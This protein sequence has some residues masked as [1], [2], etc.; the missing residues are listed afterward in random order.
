MSPRLPVAS[1]GHVRF[2]SWSL[3]QSI[4]TYISPQEIRNPNFKIVPKSDV[5]INFQYFDIFPGNFLTIMLA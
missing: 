5:F 3:G 1:R 4:V 2:L